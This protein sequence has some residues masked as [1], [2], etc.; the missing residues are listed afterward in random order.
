MSRFWCGCTSGSPPSASHRLDNMSKREQQVYASMGFIGKD[1]I[2][3]F[4]GSKEDMR[5]IV[6]QGKAELHQNDD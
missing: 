6:A 4:C 2:R 3:P 1:Y 5:C